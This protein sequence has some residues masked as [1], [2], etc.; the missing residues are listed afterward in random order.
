MK[1]AVLLILFVVGVAFAD[2][3]MHNP[4]GSNNRM[5]GNNN[6]DAVD[7][8]ARLFRSWNNADAGYNNGP[9]MYY[10]EGSL[11]DIEWT[12]NL[13]CGGPDSPVN[14]EIVLQYMCD[15]MLRDGFMDQT[16]TEANMMEMIEDQYMYGMHE[17]HKYYTDC[18]ARERNMGLFSADVMLPRNTN[19]QYTRQNPTG[20]KS[21]FECQE[22]RDYYPYWHPTPWRDIAVLTSNPDRCSYYISESQ[23]VQTKGYC[24]DP[25]FNNK[26]AGQCPEDKW[27][28][29]TAW[30]I[31]PPECKEA[32]WSRPNHMGN[33]YGGEP[34]KYTWKIPE[35]GISDEAKEHCTLRIRYNVS[36]GVPDW[37]TDAQSNEDIY[38]DFYSKYQPEGATSPIISTPYIS[39]GGQ[40]ISYGINT[41]Y[42]SKTFEDRSHEFKIVDKPLGIQNKIYNLNTRGRR[43]NIVETFPSVEHDFVPTVLR[44]K[45]WEWV[46]VQ[47]TGAD[48]GNG[49]GEGTQE[50]ERQNM[51]QIADLGKNYPVSFGEQK[52]FEPSSE[53]VRIGFGGMTVYKELC[54]SPA[55]LQRDHNNDN[56][57][58]QDERNCMKLNLGSPYFDGGLQRMN[59][60]GTFYYMSTRNNN[61]TNRSQKGTIIVSPPDCET[62]IDPET[63]AEFEYCPQDE[64]IQDGLQAA[65]A[66]V[67]TT[68]S[69]LLFVVLYFLW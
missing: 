24:L 29:G 36:S 37:N 23:N 18:N 40:N 51:V 32:P 60:V 20:A 68:V 43:G 13:G 5:T 15:P 2:V 33:T 61:F 9:S 4:R 28:E 50:T 57:R 64:Y 7:N 16:I 26:Q 38:R 22:E 58:E 11:L 30:N 41:M 53:A 54:L 14:C 45:Q 35:G 52:L 65:T 56:D 67:L 48:S 6:N 27:V 59:N 42:H 8:Q 10:Y 21:G 66:S 69:S 17:S 44:V 47:W 62:E 19:A 34:I 1:T 25:K 3:V 46:H 49:A 63:Q 12:N 55:D 31:P 39:Y